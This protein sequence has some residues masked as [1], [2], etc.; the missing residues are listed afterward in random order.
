[1]V[2]WLPTRQDRTIISCVCVD[3]TRFGIRT[4]EIRDKK[5]V[6]TMRNDVGVR[7][8][9]STLKGEHALHSLR[10]HRNHYESR[11]RRK[12]KTKKARVCLHYIAD[13]SAMCAS[14]S[15]QYAARYPMLVVC[16]FLLLSASFY[17]RRKHECCCFF[18]ALVVAFVLFRCP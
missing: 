8:S 1:M 10:S 12:K 13:S 17:C 5:N 11:R 6:W 15:R 14:Q 9:L 4:W 18:F 2:A 16:F 7:E 3:S